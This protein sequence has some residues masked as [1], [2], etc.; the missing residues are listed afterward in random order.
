M[1]DSWQFLHL[2]LAKRPRSDQLAV[3]NLVAPRVSPLSLVG[4]GAPCRLRA[5]Q[6]WVCDRAPPLP[7][8]LAVSQMDRAQ[9]RVTF[10]DVYVNFS[11]EEWELLDEPQRLLYLNVMLENFSLV[12]T[13]GKCLCLFGEKQCNRTDITLGTLDFPLLSGCWCESDGK[14]APCEHNISGEA[15]PQTRT[16]E[17]SLPMQTSHACEKYD[18]L[19]K[20]I[21]H[22]AE[23]HG[24][25]PKQVL[26]GCGLNSRGFLL[27]KKPS[28]HKKRHCGEKPIG[29]EDRETSCVKNAVHVIETPFA[30]KE[31]EMDQLNSST[32]LQCTVHNEVNL[33]K[34]TESPEPLRHRSRLG[35]HQGDSDGMPLTGSDKGNASLSSDNHTPLTEVKPIRCLPVGNVFKETSPFFNQRSIHKRETASVCEECGKTFTHLSHLKIHQKVHSGK[36]HYPCNEC[37][38]IF[39]HKSTLMQHQRV[40]TGERPFK[41]SDC[42][43]AFSRKDTLVQH[44]R[45]HTGEK[46][47]QCSECG[48]V[49]TQNSIL[50]KHQRVHTKARSYVCSKC[51]KAFGCKDTFVQ[52]QI[53]HNGTKPYECSQCGKAFSHKDTLVKHQ[54]IHT[55]EGPYI[56]SKCGK[57]FGYKVTLVHHQKI[58]TGTKPYECS[59]CGKAFRLKGTL[60]KHQNIHTGE[61]P[62]ECGECGKFFRQSSQLIVHQRIHTGAKP[63]EC[64]ECG[65]CF[66]HSSSL[67]VH[68][69][70][71]TGARPYVCKDCGKTYISSSHLVQHKKVHTGA[72]PYEC[73]ECGKFFS[74]NSSLIVHQRVHTGEKPC[75]CT[76]CGKAFSRSSHLTRHQKVHMEKRPR[77]CNSFSDLLAVPLKLV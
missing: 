73:S 51:G 50:I 39:S 33:H 40:H 74:R 26:H 11:R 48:K 69:R 75:V 23:H 17:S 15:V 22:L 3:P 4:V 62:Y 46:P 59:Q 9:G 2:I 42:D 8:H 65:K 32:L 21:L 18:P 72:R 43:K 19:L 7:A 60:V 47:Y 20:N 71:H 57:A 64:S 13:L 31:E 30:C 49:F 1:C 12:A 37:G 63:Y 28:R 45:C 44:Q 5:P 56:C 36:S 55:G 27:T 66:S 25:C 34:R 29:W 38:K 14:E 61:R 68:Q 10:E 52:H 35:K 77:V 54:K 6:V 70:V 67:I 58:H 76:D 41:C 16:A 53:I 24:L